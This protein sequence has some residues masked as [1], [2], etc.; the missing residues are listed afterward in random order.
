MSYK[1]RDT[2]GRI[3]CDAFDAPPKTIDIQVVAKFGKP[4][5]VTFTHFE[6]PVKRNASGKG[7]SRLTTVRH[8]NDEDASVIAKL[9]EAVVK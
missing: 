6:I 3:L 9:N 4:V 1:L 2:I 7:T 5:E 8:F